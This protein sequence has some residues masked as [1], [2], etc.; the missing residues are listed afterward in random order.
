MWVD[1]STGRVVEKIT[2]GGTLRNE[3]M[4]AM[5]MYGIA[6]PAVRNLGNIKIT[7]TSHGQRRLTL[8]V[9]ERILHQK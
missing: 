3:I 4:K 8:V 1:D 2:H 9:G 7:S 5:R 6:R